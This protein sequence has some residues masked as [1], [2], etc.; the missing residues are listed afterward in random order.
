[1]DSRDLRELKEL[2]EKVLAA[3]RA[4]GSVRR[5]ADL[6][7]RTLTVYCAETDEEVHP[8]EAVSASS[9][10]NV[11]YY[12]PEGMRIFPRNMVFT[13]RNQSGVDE[14]CTV[15][16]LAYDKPGRTWLAI[17]ASPSREYSVKCHVEFEP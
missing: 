12:T 11:T 17:A 5:F 4:T 15:I 1:M 2:Q 8:R 9:V 13:I 7:G 14:L 16:F 10:E 3:T 6:V